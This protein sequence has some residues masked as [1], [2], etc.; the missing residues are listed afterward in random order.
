MHEKI[1]LLEAEDFLNRMIGKQDDY[2]KFTHNLSAFLSATRTVMYYMLEELK[3]TKN[4]AWLDK[5]MNRSDILKFF[6]YTR[7]K[8]THLLPCRPAKDVKLTVP[9]T[10]ITT[11]VYGVA[12]SSDGGIVYTTQPEI[13]PTEI[14][15]TKASHNYRFDEAYFNKTSKRY[16]VKAKRLCK[17]LIK[18]Y[19]VVTF[20]SQY[21]KELNDIVNEGISKKYISG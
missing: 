8:N 20:C 3:G 4:Q 17:R 16:D 14:P 5:K 10:T 6:K 19:D 2:F 18:K 7:D 21:F 15:K 13:P 9:V 1:K 12:I 11:T